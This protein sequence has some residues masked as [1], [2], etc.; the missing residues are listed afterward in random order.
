MPRFKKEKAK[1][2][3]I[4]CIRCCKDT[5]TRFKVAAAEH[6]DYE[7]YL[8]SVLPSVKVRTLKDV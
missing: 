8:L 3:E 4:L 2:T 6:D 7:E 1:K 5:K